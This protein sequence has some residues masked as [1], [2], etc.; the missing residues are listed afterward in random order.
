[1]VYSQWVVFV[2]GLV[3]GPL[4]AGGAEPDLGSLYRAA[5]LAAVEILVDGHHSGSGSFVSAR[6]RV[7]TAAHVVGRPGRTVEVLAADGTR[8]RAEIHA[9]DLGHDV[10]LLDT[11]PRAG[12]DAFLPLAAALPP[13]GETVYLCSSAAF[14]RGLLQPGTMAREGLTF[15]YQDHFVEVAQI[16]ALIQ[17]GTSGGPW[18]NRCGELIGIQSG[19]ITVKGVPAGIANVGPVTAVRSL[20]DTG[21]HAVTPTLGLFVDEFWLLA[22]EQIGRYPPG[23][24]GVVVQSLTPDGP[25]ARAGMQKGDVLVASQGQPVRFRDDFLRGVFGRR[26]GESL[27]VKLLGPDGTGTR[28]VTITLGRLEVGWPEPKR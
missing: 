23:S 22:P 9:V 2:V 12:D 28:Q 13:P 27:D 21:R 14:R 25:A 19:S 4:A 8:R 6:G 1:V 11:E 24:E 3:A 7:A 20:L 26:P 16:A 10:L 5:R 15:E 17:E 18:L